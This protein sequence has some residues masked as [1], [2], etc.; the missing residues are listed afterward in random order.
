MISLAVSAETHTT[1]GLQ[2]AAARVT[3]QSA[4]IPTEGRAVEPGG[5]CGITDLDPASES[6]AAQVLTT[7][8]AE[9]A[10]HRMCSVTSLHL[11]P[12]AISAARQETARS[13]GVWLRVAV[14]QAFVALLSGVEETVAAGLDETSGATAIPLR[15]VAVIALF[16]R[17][18]GKV[19]AKLHETAHRAAVSIVCVAVVAVLSQAHIHDAIAAASSGAVGAA[20]VGNDVTVVCSLVAGLSRVNDS[21]AAAREGAVGAAGVGRAVAICRAIVAL[22]LPL[23]ISVSAE[24]RSAVVVLVEVA[25]AP[26]SI[27]VPTGQ[28]HDKGQRNCRCYQKRPHH[29]LHIA[30]SWSLAARSELVPCVLNN[31]WYLACLYCSI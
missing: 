10:I 9:V 2:A 4:T 26:S 15:R 3:G 20:G 1:R 22:F 5:V 11:I 30:A 18:Q 27:I 17:V 25:V 14:G 19:A 8:G 16:A 21:V 12:Y 28:K 13:A 31:R 24:G 7:R 6:V 23:P 29:P